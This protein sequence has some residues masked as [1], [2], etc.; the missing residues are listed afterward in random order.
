MHAVEMAFQCIDV[1]RPEAA[2]G[3]QPLLDF[4]ERLRLQSIEATL[5]VD[6]GFDESCLAQ[7]TQMLGDRRLR[8]A[9]S[10]LDLADRLLGR[11]EQAEYGP[12]VWLRNDLKDRFHVMNIR[13]T[14]YACQGIYPRLAGVRS[15]P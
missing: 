8:H 14:A 4:L 1:G 11:D 7:H 9:Q 5:G 3:C 13:T 10:P 2:E 12:P 6:G 15:L